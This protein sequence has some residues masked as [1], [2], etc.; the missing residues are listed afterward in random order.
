MFLALTAG[1]YGV[2]GLLCSFFARKTVT[3]TVVALTVS[4]FLCVG[5]TVLAAL[6]SSF[7]RAASADYSS[8][9]PA[10]LWLNPFYA[11]FA[12]VAQLEPPASA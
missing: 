3:A 11:L 9:D 2:L 7:F 10:L 5:T 12:L 4:I 8:H 6:L 1:V